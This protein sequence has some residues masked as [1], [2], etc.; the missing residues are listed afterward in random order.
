MPPVFPEVHPRLWDFSLLHYARPGVAEACLRLQ[1]E[2]GVNVNLLL[3]C[4]W[5]EQCGW[6]LDGARLRTAQKHIHAWDEHYV[7]PLRQL[8][9]RMKVEFGV[10][11]N[12]IEQVRTQIKHAELLAEKQLQHWLESEAQTWPRPDIRSSA[13]GANLRL[14]LQQFNVTEIHIAQLLELLSVPDSMV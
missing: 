11:D 14:Y 5:L 13:P 9:R 2:Q 4:M 1:D 6:E 10:A 3:W 12:G 7:V 8:R